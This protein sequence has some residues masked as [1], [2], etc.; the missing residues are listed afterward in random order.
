MEELKNRAFEARDSYR[1]GAIGRDE[2]REIIRP[3]IVAYN[4]KSTEIAKK[5]GLKPKKISL[6]SF[7]R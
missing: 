2:A 3:W 1:M 4:T 5:Y 6:A 7:L